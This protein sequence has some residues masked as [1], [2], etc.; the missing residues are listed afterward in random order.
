MYRQN[1]KKNK[2]YGVGGGGGP[3]A[4]LVPHRPVGAGRVA[5]PLENVHECVPWN[6]PVYYKHIQSYGRFFPRDL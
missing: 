1:Y 2:H 5:A 4:T 3:P 6:R